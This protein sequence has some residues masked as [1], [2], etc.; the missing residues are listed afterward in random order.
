MSSTPDDTRAWAVVDP[1]S[2][3][4]PRA[5]PA[6]DAAEPA[7]LRGIPGVD[8]VLAGIVV[9]GALLRF[10]TLSTQSLWADEG[11]TAQI[12][13]HS[14][15]SAVSLVPHTES[16]PPLYYALAWVW[17]HV[18]G[19]SPFALRSLPALLGT[20]TVA[21]VF[22][23]GV[24][25]LGRRAA[26]GAAALT[27]VSPIMVW[28]SQEARSY[29]LLALLCVL[30]LGFFVRALTQERR[31]WILGW[32]ACSAAA[33]ATHY[34]AVFP[35]AAE[36]A[37]LL[38]RLRGRRQLLA[39]L[40]LPAVVG[41]ALLPLVLY[42]KAH[43]PRPWTATVTVLDQ[44]EATGQSF[45]VGITWTPVI[46][47]AGVAVLT[48][49]ALGAVIALVRRGGDDERR[50]GL[51]LAALAIVTV[52]VPVVIS[53]V[54][55]NYLAPR[56]VLYAWPI[57]A[58]LVAAG[59][60]RRGAGRLSFAGLAAACAV[61]LAI[62]VAVPLT[63]ALQRDDWRDLLAPLR[64]AG[65]PRGVVVFDG[66]DDSPVL[67]YYVPGLRAPA[68]PTAVHEIDVVTVAAQAPQA[69]RLLPV[70]GLAPTAVE[71]RGKIA[72][73]RFQ[74]GRAVTLPA[75]PPPGSGEAYY[76]VVGPRAAR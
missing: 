38:V 6:P 60:V 22:W 9:F 67:R 30:A 10:A 7:R 8:P 39:A 41:L 43:V 23:A 14:L 19:S 1:G 52:G 26:L 71:V 45:L 34:F 35:L 57:L 50:A 58:L 18:F 61:C 68:R 54:A 47:R 76:E 46:H 13:G 3:T 62:V 2:S 31:A 56:N 53:L 20:L 66:F 25:L 73:T 37:W 24:P 75:A 51:G 48:L 21:A 36:A 74:S 44:V 59:A 15:S 16:T 63:P 40:A 70:P 69:A 49:A 11:F 29:A 72:L 55:T 12:A 64:V 27:A 33:L 4:G 28:Y 32:A 65:P 5:A 17:A 42:Q